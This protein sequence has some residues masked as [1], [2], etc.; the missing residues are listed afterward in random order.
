MMAPWYDT[1]PYVT[2]GWYEGTSSSYDMVNATT[3]SQWVTTNTL[4]QHDWI[5]GVVRDVVRQMPQIRVAVERQARQPTPGPPRRLPPPRAFNPYISAS[6]LLEEFIGFVGTEGVR[7]RDVLALPIDLF[8]RWL[9]IR[10][11]EEDQEE[12]NVTLDLP[13]PPPQ[14]RCLGCQRFMARAT[15]LPLH[16]QRC[17]SLYFDRE[18][19]RGRRIRRPP[20]RAPRQVPH[21][22]GA[23][24]ALVQ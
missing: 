24:R 8:V 9:I 4:T 22:R 12:P 1:S 10:A 18:A 23:R 16:G 15:P 3:T 20:G 7:Q 19:H 21:G 11:C 6:D 2:D 13:A 14:P 5:Q 17:A